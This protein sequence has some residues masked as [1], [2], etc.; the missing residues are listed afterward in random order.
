[1]YYLVHILGDAEINVENHT[2]TTMN[3]GSHIWIV[4]GHKLPLSLH[5][6]YYNKETLI[7]DME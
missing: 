7:L 1:M 2:M 6:D 3:N 4:G 5:T